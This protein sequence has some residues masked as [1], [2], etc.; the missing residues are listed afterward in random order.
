MAYTKTTWVDEVPASTPIKY[1]ISQSSD[2]DVAT[3]AT[4]EIV[5][6]VTSGTPV[7]ATNMNHIEDGIEAAVPKSLV[8]A[9]GDLIYATASGVLAR[10]A[11]PSSVTSLLSM[12]SAGTPSWRDESRYMFPVGGIFISSVS[13]N[14]ATLLGYGSWSAFGAGRVL[15]GIDA[16]QTEFDTN[17]ETGGA[18]THTLT[19]AEM[20]SHR[21]QLDDTSGG[22][23]VES[24]IGAEAERTVVSG[25]NVWSDYAGSGSAHNNLQ[26]YIVVYMWKRNS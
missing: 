2:G 1:K 9:I 15:V 24:G 21:H 8:T 11:K 23:D 7:N 10:L 5:T 6:S 4:I 17:G 25:T 26:P 3:D 18:K 16:T 19:T 22:Y 14:P 20:P 12:T 13:T